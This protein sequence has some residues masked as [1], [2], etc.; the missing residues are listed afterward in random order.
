MQITRFVLVTWKVRM[1]YS[2]PCGCRKLFKR[3]SQHTNRAHCNEWFAADRL[4]K[5]SR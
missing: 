1:F 3:F 4:P 2:K 5:N